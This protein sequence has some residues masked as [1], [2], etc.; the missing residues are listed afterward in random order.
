MGI[1]VQLRDAIISADGLSRDEA[2]RRFWLVDRQGL[3]HAGLPEDVVGEH[4]REFVRPLAEAWGGSGENTNNGEVEPI[5]LLEVVKK[6]RPTVMIGCSTSPGAFTQEVVEAMLHGSDEGA[7][8]II[9]PLSNP[10]RLAEA[11]PEQ[12]LHW[13]GGR[14]LVATGSPFENVKMDVGGK[15]MEFV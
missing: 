2:N 9:L 7:H 5:S 10:S 3:L 13:T 6:I 1:A 4:R 12:L 11:T 14:A 15:E 8:P